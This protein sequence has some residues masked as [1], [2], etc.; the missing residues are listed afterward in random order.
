MISYCVPKITK[1]QKEH[2]F[3]TM[4]CASLNKAKIEYN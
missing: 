1:Y 3:I 2:T 4:L